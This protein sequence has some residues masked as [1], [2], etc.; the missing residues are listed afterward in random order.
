LKS[1]EDDPSPAVQA[2][3]RSTSV[4]KP[5]EDIVDAAER[6]LPGQPQTLANAL[7]HGAAAVTLP[8]LLRLIERVREREGTA[9]PE[10]RQ[11]WA[12]VRGR[13]H[14][15]LTNR[16]SRIALYDLRESIEAAT[17]PLPVDFLAALSKAGDISC[18]EAVARAYER[19]TVSAG[20]H[21]DWWR[22]HLA[23]IFRTIVTREGITRRHAAVKKLDKRMKPVVDELWAEHAGGAKPASR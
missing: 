11:A 8:T 15:E 16:G 23:D 21:D 18:L 17:D 7:A 20:E 1:L 14:V 2:A 4:R 19:A 6:E 3:A 13:V 9:P 12:M 22:G 10:E 5:E